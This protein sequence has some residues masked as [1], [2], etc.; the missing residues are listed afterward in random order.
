MR[1]NVNSVSVKIIKASRKNSKTS[2]LLVAS[3]TG[4]QKAVKQLLK[5]GLDPNVRGQHAVTP[6]IE[7]S[8]KG[9]LEIARILLKAGAGVDLFTTRGET[10]LAYAAANGHNGVAQLLLDASATPD[11]H[12]SIPGGRMSAL[13]MAAGRDYEEIAT[14]LISRGA[15]IEGWR[16]QERPIVMAARNGHTEIVRLLLLRGA[17]P[18]S[19]GNLCKTALLSFAASG[20]IKGV[21]L[22]V[23]KGADVNVV[24]SYGMS[25]FLWACRNGH[26]QVAKYLLGKKANPLVRDSISGSPGDTA[27]GWAIKQRQPQVVEWLL[28]SGIQLE[29]KEV[30]Q[31]KKFLSS[32]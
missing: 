19:R 24:D 16:E 21:K 7:A 2:P 26:S 23:S 20:S 17:N 25:A 6:L 4:D 11:C 28:H 14:A 13:T 31:A 15:S 29:P 18:N 32:N 1:S 12:I 27:L 3:Q 10:A 8:A 5:R 30:K 9:F 22:L